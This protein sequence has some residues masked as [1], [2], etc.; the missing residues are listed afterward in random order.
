MVDLTLHITLDSKQLSA[1]IAA[2]K[3]TEIKS[4]TAALSTNQ[5]TKVKDAM[6]KLRDAGK[7]YTGP[8]FGFDDLNGERTVNVDEQKII[9]F[10]KKLRLEGH[11]F[12]TIASMVDQLGYKTKHGKKWKSTAIKRT[13]ENPIHDKPQTLLSELTPVAEPDSN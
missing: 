7:T 9:H 4:P 11:S 6:I 5:H 10:M 12:F 3:S 8:T 2:I 1:I 13:I